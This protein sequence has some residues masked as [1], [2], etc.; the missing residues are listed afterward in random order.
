MTYIIIGVIAYIV[1]HCVSQKLNV[2]DYVSENKATLVLTT[3]VVLAI[4][5]FGKTASAAI[6]MAMLMPV[7]AAYSIPSLLA[8]MGNLWEMLKKMLGIGQGS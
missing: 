5:L 2:V 3:L 4:H 1:I 8:K 7:M 6:L